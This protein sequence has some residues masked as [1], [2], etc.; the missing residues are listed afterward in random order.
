MTGPLD[1][2]FRNETKFKN[3]DKYTFSMFT[4]GADGKEFKSMEMEYTRVK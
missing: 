3:K 2:A 1:K 4:K